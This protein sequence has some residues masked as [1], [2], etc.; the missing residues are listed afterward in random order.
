MTIFC[1]L[2]HPMPAWFF[3]LAASLRA[4]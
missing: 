2:A 1:D 3:D 4:A